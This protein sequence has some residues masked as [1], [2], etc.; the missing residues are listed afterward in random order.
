MSPTVELAERRHSPGPARLFDQAPSGG[1]DGRAGATSLTLDGEG[2]ESTLDEL[3]AGV[4]ERLTVHAVA[5]CPVCEGHLVA[6]SASRADTAR[7][8]CRDCGTVLS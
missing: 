4:W 7:G 5:T 6:E 3:L 1:Q 8:R 2:G